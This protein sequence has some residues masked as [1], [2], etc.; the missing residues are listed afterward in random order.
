MNLVGVGGG[1]G[2]ARVRW[3]GRVEGV[4]VEYATI[5]IDISTPNRRT[6][7]AGMY[8][9]IQSLVSTEKIQTI[10]FCHVSNL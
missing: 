8:E 7:K 2:G 10:M 9:F 6:M 1:R 3:G 4:E 5:V